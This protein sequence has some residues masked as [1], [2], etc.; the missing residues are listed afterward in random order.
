VH[1][2]VEH[3]DHRQGQ[4]ARMLSAAAYIRRHRPVRRL[5]LLNALFWS[6][7]MLIAA[8]VAALAK[9]R[10]TPPGVNYLERY[11]MLMAL[12]GLGMLTSAVAVAWVNARRET[13]VILLANI[14]LS[15]ACVLALAMTHSYAGGLVAGFLIGFFGGG[16]LVTI[17]AVT[18]SI[19]P[20]YILGRVSGVREVLSNVLAVVINFVIWRIPHVDHL[21]IAALY[22][23]AA[24]LALVGLYGAWRELTRGPLPN[25]TAN[26]LWRLCRLYVLVWHRLRWIGRSNVPGRGPVILAANH[27]TGLDPFLM[28]AACLR[29][30][31]WVMLSS[32]K[33]R[34]LTPMWNAIDPIALTEGSSE[35]SKL[36][37]VLRVLK[38]GEIV[39][40]FPEGQLQREHRELQPFQQG[41]AMLAARSGAAIVP[42][43]I[44][45]TPR[46]K[47]MIWHFL[48]PTR[49]TVVFGEP[50]KPDPSK[51]HEEITQI[52]RERMLELARASHA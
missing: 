27:T 13:A 19:T 29:L 9:Q 28:Q 8:A 43:W 48:R 30:V 41:V 20:N 35:L 37:E 18:Q 40:L 36:R 12:F 32:Y 7:A 34:A 52:L 25:R 26:F 24:L 21:I 22:P 4:L 44:E 3:T 10:Y 31:R 46:A 1:V 5:V 51:T 14:L 47:R 39:G 23:T 45:G 6:M 49:S 42:V 15:A 50:F 2:R 11:S 17:S 33:Y 16:T 38:T